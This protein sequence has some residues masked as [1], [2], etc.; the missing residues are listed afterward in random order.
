MPVYR[1]VPHD[2]RTIISSSE[3][4]VS[5]ACKFN[6]S[7]RAGVL[8]EI[9]H[10]C[11]SG[12]SE[13]VQPHSLIAE[14]IQLFSQWSLQRESAINNILRLNSI[15]LC[16]RLP[17]SLMYKQYDTAPRIAYTT[18][19][20]PFTDENKKMTYHRGRIC[21]SFFLSLPVA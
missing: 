3:E 1:I 2:D 20:A 8:R 14:S 15:N 17:P 6:T 10:F 13:L 9:G 18:P 12:S 11:E 5:G 7:H 4:S 16:F 19:P 21:L